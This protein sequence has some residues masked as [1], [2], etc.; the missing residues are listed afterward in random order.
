[1]SV[2]RNNNS[3]L[4]ELHTDG[5]CIGEPGDVAEAVAKHFYTTYSYSSPP[6][7]FLPVFC[8]DFLPLVSVS[9]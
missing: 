2:F 8:S 5:N 6:L 3:T 1:M 9:D 4:I 7:S